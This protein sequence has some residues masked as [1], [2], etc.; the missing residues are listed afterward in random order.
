MTVRW[1]RRA[2]VLWRQSLDGVV[3]LPSGADEPLGLA[4]SAGA[5]WNVL[6]RP[7]SLEDLVKTLSNSYDAEPETVRRD[8]EPLLNRLSSARAIEPAS[9]Q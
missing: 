6:E 1:Q 7:V 5:L 3:V 8:I 2:D 9:P 4:G